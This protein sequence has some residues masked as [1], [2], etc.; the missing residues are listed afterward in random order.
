MPHS[1]CGDVGSIPTGSIMI[2]K[3]GK[4]GEEIATEFL[5]KKGYEILDRNYKFQIPGDLQRGEI[6]IIAKKEDTICFVEVKTLKD[7]KI[8]VFPEDK[9]NLSKKRKLIATA[10]QW[11]IKNKIPLDSK[12]QVDVISVEIKNGK[13]KISHFENA[14]SA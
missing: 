11:L 6:D 8:E 12:W 7:P 3:I 5:R 14:V 9:I 10:E 2:K 4:I 13:A 1:H